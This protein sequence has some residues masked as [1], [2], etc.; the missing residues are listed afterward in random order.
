[1]RE[2]VLKSKPTAPQVTRM[3][4]NERGVARAVVVERRVTRRPVV[5]ERRP[6]RGTIVKV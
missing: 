2:Q 6:A 4:A 1:V 3:I 5:V